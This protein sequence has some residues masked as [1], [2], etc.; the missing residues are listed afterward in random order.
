MRL[1][2]PCSWDTFFMTSNLVSITCC[3][4][5]RIDSRSGNWNTT[6]YIMPIPY[7]GQCFGLLWYGGTTQCPNNFS[8]LFIYGMKL[9]IIMISYYH[10]KLLQLDQTMNSLAEQ[11]FFSTKVCMHSYTH[12]HS[13]RCSNRHTANDNSNGHLW[14]GTISEATSLTVA[15]QHIQENLM[16]MYALLP[17]TNNNHADHSSWL[18]E[19]HVIDFQTYLSA[20]A[21]MTLSTEILAILKKASVLQ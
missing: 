4:G 5:P 15:I 21:M 14:A 11:F 8:Q 10:Y 12:C 16:F 20:A 17:T 3:S 7:A 1:S 6:P 2:R 19:C 9:F 18:C 13:F